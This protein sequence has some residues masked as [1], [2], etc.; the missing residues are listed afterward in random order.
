MSFGKTANNQE[1]KKLPVNTVRVG[2]V[3]ATT[4]ENDG[5]EGSKFYTTVLERSYKD[6][7]DWKKTQSLRVNDLPKAIVALQK[8]YEAAVVSD[9]TE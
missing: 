9:K 3:T 7:K 4:W 8:A 2:G 6:D 5:K 1:Q